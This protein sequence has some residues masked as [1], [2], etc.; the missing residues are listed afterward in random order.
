MP[1][2]KRN[3]EN[4]LLIHH[5]FDAG[6]IKQA[7]LRGLSTADLLSPSRSFELEELVLKIDTEIGN[8]P[9][10]IGKTKQLGYFE[11]MQS[12]ITGG[13][14]LSAG[15]A[16]FPSDLR[17]KQVAVKLFLQSIV[18]YQ[19]RDPRKNVNRSL[20][21]WHRVYGGFGDSLRDMKSD[22]PSFIV[23]SNVI[24]SDTNVKFEK[25]RDIL[26]KY[27]AMH[28][29]VLVIIGGADPLTLFSSKLFHP[30]KYAI[31]LGSNPKGDY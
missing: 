19:R 29:P 6:I 23:L 17:G 21:M 22:F 3:K 15:I 10:T 7:K 2:R 12:N 9:K 1:E 26:E 11:K 25:V 24:I 27:N 4:P 28:I 31:F 30:L 5:N 16:S 20:P 18:E 8:R 13:S 14:W